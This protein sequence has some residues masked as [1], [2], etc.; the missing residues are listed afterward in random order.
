[1]LKFD[2]CSKN[3]V[4]NILLLS[5]VI[6]AVITFPIQSMG[7]PFF[8][9]AFLTDEKVV[10]AD[11]SRFENGNN[12]LPG[13]YRV[14]LYVNG[15]FI[16]SHDILFKTN[17]KIKKNEGSNTN[18]DKQD[19][20]GT[21]KNDY[22]FAKDDT[23][24][25]SC[26][27]PVLLHRMN[28]NFT[29]FDELRKYGDEECVPVGSIL[30]G[31]TTYFDFGLQRLNVNIPQIFLESNIR[32]Y[33]PPGE[34][35]DGINAGL[36]G[37]NFS[38]SNGN[39]YKN[40]YLNLQSGINVGPWRFRNN[41][42]WTYY[43][44]NEQNSNR[45]Q[46]ISTYIE[47]TIAPLKSEL[48]LG[49][50]NSDSSVFDSYSFR[51]LRIYSSD[52]MYPDSQRGY[53][54]IVRGIAGGRSKVTVRQNG[55]VI[56]QMQVSAGPFEIS[57]LSPTSSSGDLE[58]T[59]E[60]K[61]GHTQK[62][63]VPY[64]SVPL[65]QREGR[66]TYDLNI[67]KYQSGYSQKSNPTII[68]SVMSIGLKNSTLYGGGQ[69]SEHYQSVAIGAGSNF[70]PWGAFSADITEGHSRLVD[71]S[72][73]AGQSLRFLYAKTLNKLGTNFQLLG[74]RYSTRGFYTLDDSTYNNMEGYEYDEYGNRYKKQ[75]LL[76]FH[77]LY[78]AKKGR[79]QINLSQHLG[80]Y[81]SL[82]LSS[83]RQ[84]YWNSDVLDSWYQFGYSTSWN[85]ISC[86]INL[87][88]N[89]TASSSKANRMT[90]LTFSIPLGS[91]L[92][93]RLGHR[94]S[95][96]EMYN[97]TNFSSSSEGRTTI[98]SGITGT[99]LENHNLS[100]GVYQGHS[101]NNGSTGNLDIL[102]R[103][104]Y[105]D[106]GI[107]YS[108][109][110]Y[111]KQWNY[112]L[113]G[114]VVA[115]ENGLTLSQPLGST[116]VLIKAPGARGVSVD[117]EAG[118]KTDWRGYAVV[119]YATV[120]RRNR[121]AL[122]TNTLDE[123]TDLDDNVISVVPTEGA[124]VRAEFKTHIGIRSLIT[125]KK[126]TGIVP[127]GAI[128]TEKQ[129]GI[130]GIVGDNGQVYLSGLPEKGTLESKWGQSKSEECKYHYHF[131]KEEIEQGIVR[132]VFNCIH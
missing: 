29:A 116:N 115:H 48:I 128:V 58:V 34:W 31:M 119:P 105:G 125:L 91:I 70:G 17:E 108:Y 92:A 9:P 94:N 113:S 118:I 51:G 64:S 43:N 96:E 95:I 90:S 130:T 88:Y 112:Q 20:K 49:D 3:G 67:G 83:S 77:N 23:G 40:Y 15:E 72:K 60:E 45:W 47:R 42:A 37:Y 50:S 132:K 89:K 129:S 53:A 28:V 111:G 85:G 21:K 41:G 98:Q 71:G 46:N 55:Y 54:P 76:D 81:G 30:P 12:Q 87:S 19:S 84:S 127:F 57:D 56:Y 124:I 25:I 18:D 99:L 33:I 32:G 13:I 69:F 5:L 75:N 122:N 131:S 1:M 63:T 100:Y 2:K 24:L 11:L 66:F 65:L 114:G 97:S 107:G 52:S 38:G 120:Y 39:G 101:K 123:H 4:Y 103:S 59:I 86:N 26:L 16:T 126:P 7:K 78:R 14:D 102:W 104:V 117:N 36:L 27:T 73:H 62:Y 68:Q 80:D 93:N 22:N 8:N 10:V 44:G 110:R 106:A 74:Y 61:D 109:D 121:I 82:Y 6:S 79:I 35:D